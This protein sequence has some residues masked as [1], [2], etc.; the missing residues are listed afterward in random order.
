MIR[1]LS[2]FLQDPQNYPARSGLPR[3][4]VCR[5]RSAQRLQAINDIPMTLPEASRAGG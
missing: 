4:G 2:K 1:R 5:W 3:V